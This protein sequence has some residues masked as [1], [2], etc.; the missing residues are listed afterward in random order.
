MTG[1]WRRPKETAEAIDA[2]CWLH[3]GDLATLRADG[4][5]KLVGRLREMFKSGGYNVYPLEVE[6]VI[7]EHESVLLVAVLGVPDPLYGEIGHAYVVARP[8]A[9]VDEGA[10]QAHCRQ[11]LANYKIPKRFFFLDEMPMLPI[12]KIDKQQLNRRSND[13]YGGSAGRA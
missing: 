1:Y 12:G 11:Q 4:N 2:E 8:G 7:E 6:K 10:L 9:S 13:E 3:T 5:L